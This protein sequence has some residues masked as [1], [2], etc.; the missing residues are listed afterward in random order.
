MLYFYKMSDNR[1]GVHELNGGEIAISNLVLGRR[2]RQLPA[3]LLRGQDIQHCAL[4]AA[5]RASP[6]DHH[7]NARCYWPAFEGEANPV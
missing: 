4:R 5:V 6:D 3:K 1:L 2:L 7:H